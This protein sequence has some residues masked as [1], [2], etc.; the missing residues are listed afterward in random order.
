MPAILIVTAL[1]VLR[2]GSESALFVYGQVA[3][4][5]VT[6][7]GV[8]GG[9][10]LGLLGGAAL[11]LLLYAGI[12]HIPTKCFFSVTNTLML[13]LAAGMAARMALFLIQA[14]LLPAL[15]NPLWDSSFALPA[16]SF[17]GAFMHTLVG[18]EATPS[19]MQVVF[20]A[21]TIVIVLGGMYWARPAMPRPS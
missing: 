11:G 19:G 5:N 10:T 2:E 4:S 20:Y 13:L 14:D 17:V 3:G 7:Y 6:A 1:A 21:A 9:V 8:A 12:L 16:N 18:Y 15:K